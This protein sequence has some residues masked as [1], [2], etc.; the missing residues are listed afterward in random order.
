MSDVLIVGGGL[1]GTAAA[2][3]LADRGIRS[4]I[5]EARSRLGGRAFSR[6]LPGDGGPPVEYGGSWGAPRHHRLQA[7]A[8][9]LGIDLVPRAGASSHRYIRDGGLHDTPCPPAETAAFDAAMTLWQA[10]CAA[11]DPAILVLTLAR[12]FD[13]RAMPGSARREILAWWSISGSSDPARARV[14]QLMDRKIAT[15]FAPKLDELGFT[16][17]GGI[18]TL[19]ERMAQASGAD[20]L[21]SAPA[22]RLTHGQKGV[23]LRLASGRTLTAGAAI[24][25]VPVNALDQ[26]R[27]DPPLPDAAAQVR[28]S[29]H[30][31]RAVKYL[32][33]A[34]GIAPGQLVTGDALGLRFLW[35]DHI[36]PDGTTLVIAFALADDLP[37]PSVAHAR[38]ALALA[39]PGAAFVSADWHD[40][41]ADP[42]ARGTWV[43]PPAEQETLH[44]PAHWGPFGPLAFAGS[45]IAPEE[46]GWFEGALA[47]GERAAGDIAACLAGGKAVTFPSPSQAN[48]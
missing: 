1:A 23:T 47:S 8:H 9:R 10:D 12:Y 19:A 31:G 32:I 21:F 5:V 13:L 26:S 46:Q 18:Q 33:R 3:R 11:A 28:R 17:A 38:A 4:T 20:L 25:A 6:S 44:D 36:R 40:W 42:F 7:L 30:I 41:L 29:G 24:V 27:F 15:G 37:E 35:S 14:S 22:E 34:R 48:G 43:S 39:F 45:D 2:L 16:V